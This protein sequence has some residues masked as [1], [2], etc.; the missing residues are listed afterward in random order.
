[1]EASQPPIQLRLRW[2]DYHLVEPVH[3]ASQRH[4]RFKS[5]TERMLAR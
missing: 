4:L 2:R 3:Y 5:Q 1:M